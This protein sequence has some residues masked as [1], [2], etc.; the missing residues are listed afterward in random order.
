MGYEDGYTVSTFQVTEPKNIKIN[1]TYDLTFYNNSYS[2]FNKVYNLVIVPMSYKRLTRM[3]MKVFYR[4]NND[5][6]NVVSNYLESESKKIFLRIW[7][8][9]LLSK[10]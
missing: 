2:E 6:N 8:R 9:T 4:K 3:R 10:N 1:L 5:D 7:K